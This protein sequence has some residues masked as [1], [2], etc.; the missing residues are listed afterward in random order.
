MKI[1]KYLNHMLIILAYFTTYWTFHKD[2]IYEF[3]FTKCELGK[4]CY[5]LPNRNWKIHSEG[6]MWPYTARRLSLYVQKYL[7]IKKRY[8][9]SINIFVQFNNDIILHVRFCWIHK[10]TQMFG[11]VVFLAII[12]YVRCWLFQWYSFYLNLEH[13]VQ[14]FT[15]EFPN[16][17]RDNL[18]F[19]YM[20]LLYILYNSLIYTV[21]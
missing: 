14:Y 16:L 20:F 11:A 19:S 10:I 15:N 18:T 1:N 12:L 6:R 17:I 2:H 7:G 13:N 8:N 5:K 21:I 4:V 9:Y 3:G